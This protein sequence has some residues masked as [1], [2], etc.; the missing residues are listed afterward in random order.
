[1]RNMV[2]AAS[3]LGHGFRHDRPRNNVGCVLTNW[4]PLRAS[5]GGFPSARAGAQC[6]ETNCKKLNPARATPGLRGGVLSR[7]DREAAETHA[8]LNVVGPARPAGRSFRH[9][10]TA[11]GRSFPRR[12]GSAGH[13]RAR[14]SEV[15]LPRIDHG[16]DLGEDFLSPAERHP[17]HAKRRQRVENR[18]IGA[19]PALSDW[20][21]P[22]DLA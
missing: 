15:R 20:S 9:L 3:A 6:Y 7:C 1:M 19:V 14:S 8:R 12:G 4:P 2:G 10:L 16:C 18:R 13:R 17:E 11:R 21:V 22:H 5:G